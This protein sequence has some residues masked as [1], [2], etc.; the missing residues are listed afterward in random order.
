MG[1][2]IEYSINPLAYSKDCNNFTVVG[3]D[4]WEHYQNKGLKVSNKHCSIGVNNLQNPMDR[5]LDRNN[6]ESIRKTMQ[7]QEDIFKNQVKEL[8]RVYNV[9]KC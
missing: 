4:A 2:K 3:V 5:I 1:T 8:H 6:M 7:I 9:Q